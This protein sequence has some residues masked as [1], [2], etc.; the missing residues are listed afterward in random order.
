MSAELSPL[1]LNRR[2]CVWGVG[3]TGVVSLALLSLT[4]SWI[5]PLVLVACVCAAL[6][7][8]RWP[9]LGCALLIVSVP[10]Q[11]LGA[12]GPLTFTRASIPIALA[13][14]LIW[15]TVTRRT[16]VLTRYT[17]PF[18]LWLLWM[19]VTVSVADNRAL[20]GAELARWAIAFGAFSIVAQFLIGA[21][22]LRS[23]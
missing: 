17:I 3:A 15:I 6:A 22:R 23:G 18:G 20:A 2:V 8:L 7:F 19:L 9:W 16:L 21:L 14:Y 13:G 11:Q 12:V 10:V 4:V 1:T 5:A